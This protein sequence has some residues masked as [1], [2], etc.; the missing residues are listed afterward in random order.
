M[1]DNITGLRKQNNLL[2]AKLPAYETIDK[3]LIYIPWP[4]VL[5]AIGDA[6]SGKVRIDEISTTNSGRFTLRGQA[7]GEVYVHKFAKELQNDGLI[8]SAKVDE[9]EYPD[10]RNNRNVSLI[11]YK[12]TCKIRLS[13]NDL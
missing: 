4:K 11:R 10:N 8:E 13:E 9:I 6:L 7:L 2:R 3:K 12:I 5:Q 1:R